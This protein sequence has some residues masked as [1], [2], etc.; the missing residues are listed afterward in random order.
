MALR[1]FFRNLNFVNVVSDL[2]SRF[3]FF[4]IVHCREIL[5]LKNIFNPNENG[6]ID[7]TYLNLINQF[8]VAVSFSKVKNIPK[9]LDTDDMVAMQRP[10]PRSVQTYIQWIWSVY[11]PTSG[12]GPTPKEVQN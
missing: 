10:E 6:K 11:G 5:R 3:I 4:L 1:P 8:F 9:L 2:A 12:Y 7:S